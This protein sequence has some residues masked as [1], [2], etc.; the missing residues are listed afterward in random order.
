[1]FRSPLAAVTQARSRALAALPKAHLHLHFTG[2]MAHSPLVGRAGQHG[3][4]LPAALMEDWPPRLS[5]TD[6]RGWFR[7]QR[8]YDT[9][10]SV[11]RQ[12]A[13]VG[14]LL[15]ENRRDGRGG[16]SG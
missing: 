3:I 5:G 15:T 12:P 1:M 13:D 4:R 6:E 11:L 2:S 14:R 9:A 8:L 10:R 16:A 7:F